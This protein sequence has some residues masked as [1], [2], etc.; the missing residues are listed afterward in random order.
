[1]KNGDDVSGGPQGLRLLAAGSGVSDDHRDDVDDGVDKLDMDEDAQDLHGSRQMRQH[2]QDQHH[3]MQQHQHLMHHGGLGEDN[4]VAAMAAMQQQSQQQNQ[5][6]GML[7]MGIPPP[8]E[9]APP[10]AHLP[11]ATDSQAWIA[12]PASFAANNSGLPVPVIV[13][14]NS[15][16]ELD[17]SL[18]FPV[19]LHLL[20]AQSGTSTEIPELTGHVIK[21]LSMNSALIFL[22]AP[23]RLRVERVIT[24]INQRSREDQ[25][26]KAKG[27]EGQR[28]LVYSIGDLHVRLTLYSKLNRSKRDQQR[29][30]RE[31]WVDVVKN[32][33]HEAR[34]GHESKLIKEFEDWLNYC[35]S[36]LQ[37][38]KPKTISISSMSA[39]PQKRKRE[40]KLSDEDEAI[41]AFKVLR[42]PHGQYIVRAING[43]NDSNLRISVLAFIDQQKR[44]ALIYRSDLDG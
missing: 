4:S 37:K 9:G 19:T 18:Q 14:T 23:T 26:G 44:D 17:N 21:F 5:Q 32:L 33:T 34:Q 30:W 11:T 43:Q 6:G 42:T 22:D 1:M 31:R 16:K 13:N 2:M 15:I 41:E 27:R 25:S 8:P 12:P 39:S 29:Q 7:Q 3:E 38:N 40:P 35:R 36:F 10:D 28:E 24:E 20:D